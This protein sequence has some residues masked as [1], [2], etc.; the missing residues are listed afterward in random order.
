[1]SKVNPILKHKPVPPPKFISVEEFAETVPAVLVETDSG[2]LQDNSTAEWIETA[3]ASLDPV[4][5]SLVVADQLDQ[6]AGDVDATTTAVGMESYRRIFGQLTQ[7]TGLPRTE[8]VSL[9]SF[10]STKGGKR[11]LAKA[12]REHATMIRG[13]AVAALEDFTDSI[14]ES[15]GETVANYKQAFSELSQL[16]GDVSPSEKPIAVNNKKLYEMWYMN[17]SVLEAKD[18][19]KEL[20]AVEQLA[21]LISTAADTVVKGMSK[22]EGDK[23]RDMAKDVLGGVFGKGETTAIP[24]HSAIQLMFNTTVT[25]DGGRARFEKNAVPAPKHGKGDWT[26]GD[27]AWIWAWGLL[28]NPLAGVGAYAYR[29]G[30]G[31]SGKGHEREATDS[32]LNN[33]IEDVKRM[34]PIVSRIQRDVADLTKAIQAAA[35]EQQAAYKRG[36]AP[37]VEMASKTIDHIANVTYGAKTLMEKLSHQ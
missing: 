10:G 24:K 6:L 26:G 1:M 3:D 4:A 13:C 20:R 11:K 23:N 36:A 34:G 27:W 29:K 2:V 15:I 35:G 14:D 33:F 37:V 25:F 31:G 18:F 19:G 32:E 9:E 22:T 28:V 30:V 8:G 5:E 16:K 12:I 17:G 21:D 7:A